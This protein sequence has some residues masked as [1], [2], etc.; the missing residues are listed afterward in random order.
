MKDQAREEEDCGKNLARTWLTRRAFL[1][2]SGLAAGL[3]SSWLAGC[4]PNTAPKN[5]ATPTPAIHNVRVGIP[6]LMVPTALGVNI[7]P[8]PTIH[9]D[10][11]QLA[12]VGFRAVRLDIS[13]SLVE[14]QPGT[15][16]FS[17]YD[18]IIETLA[19]YN[20]RPLCILGYNNALYEHTS[21]PP[22]DVV[23]PHTDE[24]RQAFARFAAA[25]AGHFKGQ[26]IYW[27]VWNEPD[28]LPFWYPT[29][30][31]D[32]YM[33]LAKLTIPAIRQADPQATV[34]APALTGL[35]PQYQAA[36][37][38]L[39][40]CL[41]LGLADLADALSL[42]PYRLDPPESVTA[43]Y[44][45]LRA[46]LARWS[47]QHQHLPLISSE[48]G[49]SLT[50]VSPGQQ[51]AYFVRLSLLNLLNGLP[52]S[53]WYEW[54]D[55]GANPKQVEDNFGLLTRQ[56]QPKPAYHAA[57]SLISELAGFS[58]VER[59][60]LPSSADYVLLF[61]MGTER[62]QVAWTA[63]EPHPVTLPIN[64]PSVTLTSMTGARRS[65]EIMHGALQL[66]LT[67]NPQYVTLA[68]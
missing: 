58:L 64:V 56:N 55:D 29:P 16:D 44:Q 51:A 36:W 33:A 3:G 43:D 1:R 8:S 63:G 53:I 2:A 31:A 26:G 9:A 37:T 34:V 28:Y 10:I 19:A 6:E 59:V 54:R 66:T 65:Q 14:R 52:M 42:H 5:T 45:R 4:S 22:G 67:G 68:H 60:V 40:R 49:Y 18:P 24:V 17:R 25:A 7:H 21:A 62:K 48:W 13:W 30:L 15:Y 57:Q 32:E 11:M 47:P 12:A 39:E 41:V 50:W 46:L 23:G 61:S 35:E 20:I 38:F 27:E